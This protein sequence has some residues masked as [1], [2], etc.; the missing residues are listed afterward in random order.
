VPAAH[1]WPLFRNATTRAV[2]IAFLRSACSSRILGDLPPNSSVTRFIDAAPSRMIDLPT[3]TE[4]VN[5]I[6]ATS[7]FR[8]SSAPTTSPRPITTLQRPFGSF[9]SWTHSSHR[10][11]WSA[12]SS[13]GF[14]QTVQ[15][16]ATAEASLAQTNNALAFQGVI[17]P[18]TP[19]GSKVT[20]VLS[21][22]RVN[23]S[24]WS[25]FSAARNGVGPDCTIGEGN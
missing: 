20:V 1:A 24:S 10:W 5:E 23:G 22:L 18:A 12:L 4:P 9:A 21:Q 15:P 19:T 16:A 7:G 13:L 14:M 2:G 3:P 17:R 25:A 11:V 6:F 8:T